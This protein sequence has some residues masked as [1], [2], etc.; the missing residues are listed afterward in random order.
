M[1]TLL[2]LAVIH[3]IG[4]FLLQNNWMAL[5]KSKKIE[6]LTIHCLI[7]SAC[8]LFLGWKFALVTFWL[9]FLTDF[10]TSRTSAKFW[11]IQFGNEYAPYHYD[12]VVVDMSKRHWFFVM[13]GADQL[14]HLACLNYT[15]QFVIGK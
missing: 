10:F 3:F 8:F 9:H 15:W 2:D 4:D 14:I 13:L 12:S 1:N 11:F 6:A 5:N 7:Y